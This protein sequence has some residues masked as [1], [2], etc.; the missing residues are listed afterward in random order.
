MARV[1]GRSMLPTLR[2]GDLLLVHLVHQGRSPGPGQVVV[3]LLPGGRGLGVK[4][5]R[6]IEAQGY[7]LEGDNP[8]EGTDSRVFGPVPAQ[9]IRARVVAR[10]WPR[11][12]PL[13]QGHSSAGTARYR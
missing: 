10:V 11:P 12:A 6:R 2:E 4:R 13:G 9:H 5:V 3:A 8:H 7:W 1:R